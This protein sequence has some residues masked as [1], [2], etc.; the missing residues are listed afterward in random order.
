VELIGELIEAV[1]RRTGSPNPRPGSD[2]L[3]IGQTLIAGMKETTGTAD[4]DTGAVFSAGQ[5]GFDKLGETLR[6]AVPD[7]SWVGAGA[8]GYADQNTRQQLR[9]ENMAEADRTV[10]R[11]LFREAAQ[12]T[13]RRAV[14]D[15][16]ANFLANA[17]GATLPLQLIPHYGEAAKL[18]IEVSALQIALEASADQLCRLHSD[19]VA[20]AAEL[21]QAVGRYS[22]VADG[23]ATRLNPD[24]S[25]GPRA[26]M[27]SQEKT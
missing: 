17:S 9:A 27:P 16:H 12:I 14:L 19:V 24:N 4:P 8:R 13:L 3:E 11:V 7:D 6:S 25:P 5:S 22:A 2:L 26:G 15:E 20:N 10:H 21:Q 18:A 1:S 23:A